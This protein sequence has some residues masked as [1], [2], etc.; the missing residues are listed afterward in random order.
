MTYHATRGTRHALKL[1]PVKTIG[2]EHKLV[3]KIK[4]I[5]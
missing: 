5:R 2:V 4:K 1:P 3:A